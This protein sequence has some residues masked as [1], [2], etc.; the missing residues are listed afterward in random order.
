M[1]C[2]RCEQL[3]EA[4]EHIVQW[5]DAYPVDIFHEPSQDECRRA[6]ELL[7]A[8]GMTLDAFSASMGRRCLQG[9]GRIAREA[10]QSYHQEIE[11]E[12]AK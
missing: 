8:N 5:A 6:H 7:A 9:V 11:K 3:E 2:E 4:L 1:T 10:L 12:L